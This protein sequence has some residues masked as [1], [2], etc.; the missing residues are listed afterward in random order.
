MRVMMKFY[1]SL[2]NFI[3]FPL[4][5]IGNCFWY[6]F[7]QSLIALALENAKRILIYVAFWYK[8]FVPNFMWD[9]ILTS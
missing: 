9:F 2:H 6:S 1:M 7:G 8:I 4:V 3:I 5:P